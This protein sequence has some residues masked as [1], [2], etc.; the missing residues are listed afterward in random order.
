MYD[1]YADDIFRYI[2]VHVR[3]HELAEDLTA[4]TFVRAWKAIETFDFS[5]PR[6]WLY[7]I[8]RNLI[9]DHWRR[10]KTELLPEEF[11]EAS[12]EDI[13][14]NV[15]RHFTKQRVRGALHTLGEPMRSVVLL[16]FMSGYSVRQTADS[17]GLSESNVRVL[18]HRALKQ[19]KGHLS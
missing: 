1:T 6:P 7:K 5:Q 8:A 11:E 3:D 12:D 19:L 10:H 2:F 4:D 14:E 17:L 9:T 15:E 13:T 18:Q 16:R